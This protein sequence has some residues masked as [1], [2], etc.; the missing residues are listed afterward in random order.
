MHRAGNPDAENDAAN[1]TAL[2]KKVGLLFIVSFAISLYVQWPRDPGAADRSATSN[3]TSDRTIENRPQIALEPEIESGTPGAADVLSAP[4]TEQ[5][6]SQT[7]LIVED[8]DEP[9]GRPAEQYYAESTAA[10]RRI[11]GG[12]SAED[13]DALEEDENDVATLP[14]GLRYDVYS[15]PRRLMSPSKTANGFLHEDS[16]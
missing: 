12:I 14:S 1:D 6:G 2:L 11:P 7:A 5:T 8:I 15:A 3:R 16:D 13:L 10:K 4:S 9:N